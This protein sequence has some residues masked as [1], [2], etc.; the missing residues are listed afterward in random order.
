MNEPTGNVQRKEWCSRAQQEAALWEE[1]IPAPEML[2]DLIADRVRAR[3]CSLA[4]ECNLV[5]FACQ[6]AFTNPGMDPFA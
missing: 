4:I 6:W 5:G 1:R 2:G 3:G